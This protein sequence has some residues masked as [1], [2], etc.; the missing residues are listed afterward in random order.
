[1]EFW[2]QTSWVHFMMFSW[3]TSYSSQC[4]KTN[5]FFLSTC[6]CQTWSQQNRFLFYH[7]VTLSRVALGI[8]FMLGSPSGAVVSVHVQIFFLWRKVGFC[9]IITTIQWIP[10]TAF[11]SYR[12]IWFRSAMMT[13][14]RA[15]EIKQ[16][17]RCG[18]HQQWNKQKMRSNRMHQH[19][20]NDM[21][22]FNTY[23]K[24]C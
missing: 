13:A 15:T 18:P 9:T 3:N 12:S 21:L 19:K 22:E 6:I 17:Y 2:K 11:A 16:I 7:F 1:M 5:F 23:R 10:F 14:R 8:T 4:S 24:K 20:K